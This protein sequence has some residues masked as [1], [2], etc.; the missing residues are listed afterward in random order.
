M[1]YIK[2]LLGEFEIYI[3]TVLLF[4]MFILLNIQVFSR[5]L[6]S[7]SLTWT[8]ELSTIIFVWLGYLGASAAVYKQQH[9]RID[10]VLNLFHGLPKKIILIIT[11]LITMAFCIIMI[12]PLIDVI[13]NFASLGA[14]TL[15]LRI[16]MDLVYWVLPF[17]LVLQAIRFVQDII[18][19][20]KVPLA[21]DVS[22]V[23]ETIFDREEE[24]K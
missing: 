24:T 3:G 15:I 10:V 7:H 22:V 23:G 18:R 14:E 21:E 9:L 16:P 19:I 17:A 2:K 5:Y 11:D 4:I 20:L 6:F 8:E 13:N 1:K 12:F